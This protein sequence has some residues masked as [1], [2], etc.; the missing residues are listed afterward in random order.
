METKRQ[1]WSWLPDDLR[2]LS[3]RLDF[4][5]QH[6]WLAASDDQPELDFSQVTDTCS[7]EQFLADLDTCPIELQHRTLEMTKSEAAH[8]Y[9][10][11]RSQS[12]NLQRLLNATI[13][14][15]SNE[16]NRILIWMRS[17]QRWIF[18]YRIFPK[19]AWDEIR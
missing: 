17:R 10:I 8:H 6:S 3:R 18:D 13:A 11:L 4:Q 15:L 9:G 5:G 7:E 1:A 2:L 14:A 12:K 19:S 16:Q